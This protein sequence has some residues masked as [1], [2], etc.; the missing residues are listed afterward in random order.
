MQITSHSTPSTVGALR[1]RHLGLGDGALALDVDRGAAEE[2]VDAHA[3]LVALQ[4]GRDEL[5]V[6]ALEP[7]RPHPAFR[8]PDGAEAVPLQAVAPHRPVLD[9]LADGELVLDVSLIDRHCLVL[10]AA[11]WR[12]PPHCTNVSP[13]KA[14]E[15]CIM[16]RLAGTHGDRDR[17]GEGHRAALFAGAGR[18]GR[19]GDDR[20]HRRRLGARRRDRRQARPQLHRQHDLRRQRRGAVQGA[21]RQDHRALRQDRHPDQQRRALRAAADAEGHRHR[22]RAVGQ[23]DGDQHPRAVPDG[24]ARR[25]AHDRARN[26]A[27]SST[28]APARSPAA[29]RSSRITSP[30]RAR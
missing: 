7:G 20:R 10:P 4:V 30:R 25:P 11:V 13:D 27:R 5:L 9:Q 12:W 22:R 26:T 15:E 19:P 23:G 29:S 1:D 2:V 18:R 24:Q 16:A 17:R 28:S 3:A 6:G 14:S 8:V 21:G